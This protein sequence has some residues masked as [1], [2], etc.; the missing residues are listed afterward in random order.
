MQKTPSR[1]RIIFIAIIIL[2]PPAPVFQIQ[3]GAL[4]IKNRRCTR[5][6]ADL[7]RRST[8]MTRIWRIKAPRV[9]PLEGAYTYAL[10]G[11][12][13]FRVTETQIYPRNP[14]SI[15]SATHL[16]LLEY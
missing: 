13:G 4:K 9:A 12:R 2:N 11:I 7:P 1:P 15:G 8:R 3:K 10:R 16:S 6:N 14:R 5:M